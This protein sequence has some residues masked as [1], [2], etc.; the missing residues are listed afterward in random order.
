MNHKII[1]KMQFIKEPMPIIEPNSL[2]LHSVDDSRD[3][4]NDVVNDKHCVSVTKQNKKAV[5]SQR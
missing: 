4:L 5:P 2:S 3:R 1:K